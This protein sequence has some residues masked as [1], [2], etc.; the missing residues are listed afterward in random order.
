MFHTTFSPNSSSHT[1]SLE[2]KPQIRL[3]SRYLGFQVIPQIKA[4]KYFD[5]YRFKQP[6]ASLK[7]F[8][9]ILL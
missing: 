9:T 4:I 6:P 7:Y 3:I 2:S 8:D 1:E 5:N